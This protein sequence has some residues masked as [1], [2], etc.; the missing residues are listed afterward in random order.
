M[1]ICLRKIK[2]SIAGKI[3]F[4]VRIKKIIKRIFI[5]LPKSGKIEE[6]GEGF[7]PA[8]PQ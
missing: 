6:R 3:D 7:W 1:S 5:N 8:N 4:F 2:F